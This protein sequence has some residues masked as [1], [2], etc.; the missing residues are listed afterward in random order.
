MSIKRK[1]PQKTVTSCNRKLLGATKEEESNTQEK[2]YFTCP[3]KVMAPSLTSSEGRNWELGG[4]IDPL[5][6]LKEVLQYVPIAR[7]TFLEGVSSGRY[8]APVRHLG[9]RI[10]AWKLSDIKKLLAGE[11]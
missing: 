9:P 10:T 3:K 2:E 7:S 1:E 6:R 11:G 5:I 8:P 4:K